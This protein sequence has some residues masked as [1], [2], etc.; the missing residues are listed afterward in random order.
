MFVSDSFKQQGD[1]FTQYNTEPYFNGKK[2]RLDPNFSFDLCRL[3]CSIFDYVIDDFDDL[4]SASR[5]SP[6]AK[7]IM[8]WCTDDNNI[9]VLY[10]NNGD[11]RYPDFKL[12]KMISRCVHNH[13]PINQLDR[14]EFQQFIVSKKPKKM[15]NI[16]DIPS[17]IK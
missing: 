4:K 12:Y 9:N 8:E 15:I 16:D 1:A 11:E 17:Y 7:L 14:K 13:T 3:A 5:Q 10:K 6:I 2:P